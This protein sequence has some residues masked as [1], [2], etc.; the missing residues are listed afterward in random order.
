MSLLLLRMTGR[1]RVT[2]KLRLSN[3]DVHPQSAKRFKSVPIR[4]IERSHNCQEKQNKTKEKKTKQN[5]INNNQKKKFRLSKPQI[6]KGF[7]GSQDLSSVT[8]AEVKSLLL[9]YPT[10]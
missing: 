9:N 1:Q 3:C 6:G 2:T 8:F 7:V 4:R 5:Q 10:K